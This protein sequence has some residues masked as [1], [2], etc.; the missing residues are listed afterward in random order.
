M[1]IWVAVIP[2]RVPVTF[3]VHVAEVILVAE[4]IGE[5]R[6]F[7]VGAGVGDKRI[8]AKLSKATIIKT[9]TKILSIR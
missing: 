6:I 9:F 7:G 3:E 1:S 2:S 5:H 4:D 8:K